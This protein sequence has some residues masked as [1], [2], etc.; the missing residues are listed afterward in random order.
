MKTKYKTLFRR[1]REVKT[2]FGAVL[3]RWE[4]HKEE[5]QARR[6]INLK[7]ISG[8]RVMTRLYDSLENK[9]YK[10][11]THPQKWQC[12]T[13]VEKVYENGVK[14]SERS[15]LGLRIDVLV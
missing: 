9:H 14:V 11:A 4:K 7:S 5:I 6:N 8:P 12:F 10:I 15:S 2:Y 1:A 13:F 3:E